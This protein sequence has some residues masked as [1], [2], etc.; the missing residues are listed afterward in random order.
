MSGC[1]YEPSGLTAFYVAFENP[2]QTM[3]P[4]MKI[5]VI[6]IINDLVSAFE[7]PLDVYIKVWNKTQWSSLISSLCTLLPQHD[8]KPVITS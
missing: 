3:G 6:S 7:N 5:G 4:T 1:P 8:K 2:T